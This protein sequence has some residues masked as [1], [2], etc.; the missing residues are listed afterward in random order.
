MD[1]NV[2]IFPMLHTNLE[3]K[4]VN[5]ILDPSFDYSKA[6]CN[7][8]YVQRFKLVLCVF[9][10]T[11]RNKGLKFY[12]KTT[13]HNDD[14][15]WRTLILTGKLM[16]MIT[17][18]FCSDTVISSSALIA[19]TISK[20]CDWYFTPLFIVYEARMAVKGVY[21]Y[22]FETSHG[23][24]VSIMEGRCLPSPSNIFFLEHSIHQFR[25][26]RECLQSSL[27]FLPR[28]IVDII[29]NYAYSNW[30]TMIHIDS[31]LLDFLDAPVNKFC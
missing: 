17:L 30:H 13:T 11:C 18:L 14:Q 31:G 24:L 10:A 25:S 9:H 19:F 8:F 12:K 29:V 15:T 4:L 6:W 20:T 23:L 28:P 22:A 16:W 27:P 21:D 26:F 7:D 3:K 5:E 1:I 2:P